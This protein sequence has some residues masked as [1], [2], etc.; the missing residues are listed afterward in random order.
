LV[1][2]GR[3]RHFF[4]LDSIE[5]AE[6]LNNAVN[7]GFASNALGLGLEIGIDDL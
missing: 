5:L 7:F 2:G 6:A 1:W 4:I 3:S